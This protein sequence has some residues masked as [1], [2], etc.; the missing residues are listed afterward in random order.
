VHR[1]HGNAAASLKLLP[2]CPIFDPFAHDD[3]PE[4]LPYAIISVCPIGA[5]GRHLELLITIGAL[6]SLGNS[7]TLPW[8]EFPFQPR[9]H[10][11]RWHRT[12]PLP[13]SKTTYSIGHESF[14]KPEV[15]DAITEAVAARSARVE[16]TQDW[17]LERS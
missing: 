17:V 11:R 12:T 3:E 4:T 1:P 13:P 6:P 9:H 7:W 2:L 8:G 16:V 15:Q 14:K 10:L 5:E